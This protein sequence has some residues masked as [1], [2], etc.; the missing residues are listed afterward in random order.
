MVGI[1][2]THSKE[3]PLRNFG[4]NVG[5]ECSE[6]RNKFVKIYIIPFYVLKNK[7]KITIND[8]LHGLSV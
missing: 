8:I 3:F 5:K 6:I 4:E 1:L 7:I 2:K